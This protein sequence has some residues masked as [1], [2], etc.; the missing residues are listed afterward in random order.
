MHKHGVPSLECAPYTSDTTLDEG[1]CSTTC[2]DG[3]TPTLYK[4]T[5]LT[6]LHG[7]KQIKMAILAGGPF[8]TNF[9]VHQNLL[10]YKSG[11][12]QQTKGEKVGLHEVKLIGW[13]NENGVHY[14]I[15][16]NSWGESWGM[17]GFFNIELGACGI[18]TG[19]YSRDPV[20][21]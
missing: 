13:G 8:V 2:A 7:D 6:G 10:S 3:T 17:D 4:A 5:N 19:G 18:G 15:A 20:A 14:W 12:Y 16:A 11:I 21:P 1:T 9:M